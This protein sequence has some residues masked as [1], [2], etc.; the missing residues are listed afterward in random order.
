MVVGGV[1]SGEQIV[2]GDS[3]SPTVGQPEM[4][5][6]AFEKTIPVHSSYHE[7]N[8]KGCGRTPGVMAN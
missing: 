6:P 8:R 5:S 2:F 7:G 3:V 4:E 1:S